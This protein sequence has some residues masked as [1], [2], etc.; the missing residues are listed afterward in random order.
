MGIILEELKTLK[1]RF[2]DERR[3]DIIERADEPEK[4]YESSIMAQHHLWSRLF[5]GM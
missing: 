5:I 1:K 2:G 4:A 3:S